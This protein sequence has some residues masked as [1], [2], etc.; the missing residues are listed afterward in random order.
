MLQLRHS[1]EEAPWFDM[2]TTGVVKM[3][4]SFV[5]SLACSLGVGLDRS[6]GVVASAAGG[7]GQFGLWLYA[8]V[9]LCCLGP[10]TAG[11]VGLLA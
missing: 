2:T 3:A 1:V 11:W 4:R 9:T 5:R 8:L 6:L 7:A 10:R